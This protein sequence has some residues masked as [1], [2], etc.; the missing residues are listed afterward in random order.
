M[1][2]DEPELPP[3]PIEPELLERRGEDS[4]A[5]GGDGAAPVRLEPGRVRFGPDD[6]APVS[7]VA[8]CVS[9]ER[10]EWRAKFSSPAAAARI[11]IVTSRR[12]GRGWERAISGHELW[13]PHP[14]V[15]EYSGWIGPGAY[16]APGRYVVRFIRD[17]TV[18]AEGEFELL[19][20]ADTGSERH[21]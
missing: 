1:A 21:H 16:D 20:G 15:T 2:V 8:R 13:L 19:P 4:I 18:L 7:G 11:A 6:E 12:H 10:L 17:A 3:L 5:A 14:G 9:G